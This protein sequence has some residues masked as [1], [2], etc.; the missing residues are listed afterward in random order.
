MM[1]Y[2][3]CSPLF[4]SICIFIIC[5]FHF[6]NANEDL[7]SEEWIT[8]GDAEM[9]AKNYEKATEYFGNAIKQDSENYFNYYKRATV[10]RIRNKLLSAVR[11]LNKALNYNPTH[12]Q[13]LVRRGKIYLLLGKYEKSINDLEK[14]KTNRLA[15]TALDKA[16]QGKEILKK[17]DNYEE[18]GDYNN[19][20]GLLNKLLE[21]SPDSE[22]LYSRSA[23]I[24]IITKDYEG[25]IEDTVKALKVNSKNKKMLVLRGRALFYIGDRST[26]TSYYKQAV[27]LDTENK[28]IKNEFKK[29]K[30]YNK[31][32]DLAEE[33]IN[34]NK[35][36]QETL[37]ALDIA[38][39][40]F[41]DVPYT[42]KL[43]EKKG[44]VLVELKKSSEAIVACN[45]ALELDPSLVEALIWR[46]DA[47]MLKEDWDAAYRDFQ[48]AKQKSPN[49]QRIN[50]RLNKAQK[51]QKLASRKDYYKILGVSKDANPKEIKKAYRRAALE[52]H[53]DKH[54]KD[55]KEQMEREFEEI[56]EAYEVLSDE[57]KRGKYDRGE[58]LDV[59]PQQQGFHGF[60]Q[61]GSPFNFKFNFGG[62]GR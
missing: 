7:T 42:I 40:A 3:Y 24:K 31:N 53:P 20:L 51:Q 35:F 47:H 8:K 18:K 55:M 41:P 4:I 44:R 5:F 33:D 54:P 16:K 10:Y 62:F 38:I 22:I 32:V 49:D 14:V 23:N 11:D 12:E 48:S 13:S 19:A 57:E 28:E 43:I 37:D 45:K 17:I 29:V 6:I 26:A 50:S 36:T 25:A 59:P 1:K 27:K 61:G 2:S 52:K 60:R 15:K 9:E 39:D 21:I 46:G 34:N 30:K 58:D 56:N